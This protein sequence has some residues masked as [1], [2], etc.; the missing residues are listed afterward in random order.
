M[1][2]NPFGCSLLRT[3]NQA[4]PLHIIDVG[5]AGGIDQAWSFFREKGN[6]LC[7]G[8][9]PFPS[10]FEELQNSSD[11]IF[12]PYA[13]SDEVG[14]ADFYGYQTCGSLGQPPAERALL[15]DEEYERLTVQT[16]TLDSLRLN[17]VIPS[18]DALKIDVE[19]NEI[20]VL[21]GGRSSIQ[22]ETLYVKAEFSFQRESNNAFHL[23]DERLRES[24]FLLFNFS[25]KY[26]LCRSLIGGD[27][28][29]FKNIAELLKQDLDWEA[30][31]IQVGK[32]ITICL[33]C[34][35][36]EYAYVCLKDAC[37]QQVLSQQEA[38]ELAR[39]ITQRTHL[40]RTIPSFPG[41]S[42]LAALL[43]I[44]VQLL[45]GHMLNKSTP[46]D[47]RLHKDSQLWI[48]NKYWPSFLRKRMPAFWSEV[49]RRRSQVLL[50]E[51]VPK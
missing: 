5:A 10:N 15:F 12:Y 45:E 19:G 41:K 32:L 39:F 40:P 6:F 8:F 22:D 28:L 26:S 33:M 1:P 9:E 17:S 43:F 36:V 29:Y 7:F 34:H 46:K 42:F 31:R 13:I 47:N 27:V 3:I 35:Y 25:L 50:S 49:Y 11:A 51:G 16:E 18:I 4:H 48:E 38:D 24:G 20:R 30:L 14:T 2:L 37:A 44:G 21:D 23:I